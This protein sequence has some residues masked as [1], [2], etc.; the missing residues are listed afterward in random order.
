MAASR[1]PPADASDDQ[2]LAEKH[3]TRWPSGKHSD[4]YDITDK[5]HGFFKSNC[6]S[7][8]EWSE[9]E[10]KGVKYNSC[11]QFMMSGKARLFGDAETEKLI[12]QAERP[13]EQKQLGRD[14]K[15]FEVQVWEDA[16]FDIVLEGNMAKFR[17]NEWM[18]ERLL[19]SGAKLLAEGAAYDRVWGIG[20]DC[21]DQERAQDLREWEG[22][23]YLGQV[24]MVVR[25]RLL[26]EESG[27]VFGGFRKVPEDW[28]FNYGD[29][30]LDEEKEFR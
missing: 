27:G 6:F 2:A 21:T 11:E 4:Y 1:V 15:N 14:V 23:N 13:A 8:W 3:M 5:P 30:W 25:R 18:R 29:W 20:I 16:C 7:Q 10:V 22:T 12:M 19:N 28:D 17:Q 9:F 24:L 26:E